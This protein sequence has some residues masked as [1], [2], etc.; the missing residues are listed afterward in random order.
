VK[1]RR[2]HVLY[3]CFFFPPSRA[4]GVFRG[5]ATANHL[6]RAGWD[7]TVITAPREFFTYHLD[8]AVDDALEATVDPS[9]RVERPRMNTYNWE[10][11]LRRYGWLRRNFPLLSD[12]LNRAVQ[13]AV[14]PERYIGWLPAMLRRAVR[15]RMRHRIDLVVATGNPF[16]SFAAARILGRLFRVPYVVDYRDAW[17]FNQF[18]EELTVP[19]GG[20]VMRWQRRVLDGAAEAVFVNDGMRQWHADRYPRAA[21]RMTVVRNGW[22]SDVLGEVPFNPPDPDRPLRFAFIG[23]V[24][25]HLPLDVLFEAWRI[26]RAHP[27]L[28]GAELTMHGHLGF[29]PHTVALMRQRLAREHDAG[30]RYRGPFSKVEAAAAYGHAD[31]LIFCVGGA[32]MVTSGKV[33]EYLATGKPIVSA[34]LPGIAAEEVL[35]GYPLWFAEPEFDPEHVARSLVAAAKAA[36]DLDSSTHQAAVKHAATFSRDAVVA[37]WEGRLRALVE[38]GRRR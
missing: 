24:T 28:A 32:R 19:E 7:V 16:V 13:R 18:T 11:D 34:H 14:F 35:Q 31:V 23:T 12:A 2:P 20:K 15:V 17:T 38:S 21:A 33:F 26:A 3:L 5:R 30:V 27:L 1:R 22:D 36:R 9:I 37:P 25:T 6:A 4:S 10:S 8:G 29:F